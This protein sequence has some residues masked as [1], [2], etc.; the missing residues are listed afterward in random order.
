M[1]K[2]DI[3]DL[4]MDFKHNKSIMLDAIN[5]LLKQKMNENGKDVK[6]ISFIFEAL[7]N[8]V[9]TNKQVASKVVT[10]T[11]ILHSF[12][13]LLD[14]CSSWNTEMLSCL[15]QMIDAIV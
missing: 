9:V 13:H 3:N 4:K 15:Y 6:T 5:A 2:T 14:V 10:E 7:N 1:Q 12:R 8:I 11:C